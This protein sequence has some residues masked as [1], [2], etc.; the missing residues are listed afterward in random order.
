MRLGLGLGLGTNKTASGGGGSPVPV[1]TLQLPQPDGTTGLYDL[2]DWFDGRT[3]S[4]AVA[5]HDGTM[6][7]IP[8]GVPALEGARVQYDPDALFATFTATAS[9]PSP[10]DNMKVEYSDGSTTGYE[11]NGKVSR[12]YA[13]LVDYD[14]VMAESDVLKVFMGNKI[15]LTMFYFHGNNLTGS[16]PDLSSSPALKTFYCEENNLTGSISDLSA[17]TAL[18]FFYCGTNELTGVM[19]N[20][21]ANTALITFDCHENNLTGSIPGLSANTALTR[22]YCYGNNLTGS[23]PS[24][25]SNTSLAGFYCQTNQLT[26]SIPSLSSNTA[27][28]NFSCNNNQLTGSI[29]DLSSNTALT[30][31]YCYDNQLT[32]SIP[33]LSSNTALK[34]FYCYDNQ[35]TGFAGGWP[36][37]AFNFNASINALTE[38][39]VNQILIDAD[40]A[41]SIGNVPGTTINVSVGTNAA[42]TG[43]GITAKNNL[44]ANGATVTTN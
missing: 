24:L 36:D 14:G 34:Y 39:A 29:P 19:P 20:L 22:F 42:P 30:H 7:S 25:S 35:L 3:T 9:T 4:I 13:S 1:T 10:L 23:I 38:S 11:R 41:L 6:V 28:T 31:F 26:G 15:A 27:L 18:K 21:S 17:N 33:N 43:A 37:S 16:F 40:A 44:V 8:A 5:D 12:L 32:G 2:V